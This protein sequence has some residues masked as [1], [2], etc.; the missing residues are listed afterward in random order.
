M[1]THFLVSDTLHPIMSRSGPNLFSAT[2]VEPKRL[3]TAL[4][5]SRSLCSHF[6]QR[7]AHDVV[8]VHEPCP[9]V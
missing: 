2:A 6:F 5:V 7:D 1:P 4:P 3:H 8:H 9:T